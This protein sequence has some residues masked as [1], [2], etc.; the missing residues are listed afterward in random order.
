MLEINKHR[1]YKSRSS[2]LTNDELEGLMIHMFDS[3]RTIQE[4]G[5]EPSVL[6]GITRRNNVNPKGN[7]WAVFGSSFIPRQRRVVLMVYFAFCKRHTRGNL[8]FDLPHPLTKWS[9]F[10][11]MFIDAWA[12][13]RKPKT[14]LNTTLKILSSAFDVDFIE[15]L[16]KADTHIRMDETHK[17]RNEIQKSEAGLERAIQNFKD[18]HSLLMRY[19]DQGDVF[20]TNIR[21][22]AKVYRSESKQVD[23]QL[24]KH[25]RLC[26]K[27]ENILIC[28]AIPCVNHLFKSLFSDYKGFNHDF[29][30]H[31]I[32]HITPS[33]PKAL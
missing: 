26:L 6:C 2:T 21:A 19:Y 3:G 30:F 27:I 14:R 15:C 28:R 24:D 13:A 7:I 16:N 32:N 20:R 9:P 33:Q 23:R 25:D 10:C 18:F 31:L 17:L 4:R 12:D 8:T 22:L 5:W 11:S 29:V 1:M